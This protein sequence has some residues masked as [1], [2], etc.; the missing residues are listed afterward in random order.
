MAGLVATAATCGPAA[1]Q[2]ECRL[3]GQELLPPEQLDR[4]CARRGV[5]IPTTVSVRSATAQ[6]A[7]DVRRRVN[8]DLRG[9][10]ATVAAAEEGFQVASLGNVFGDVDGTFAVWTNASVTFLENERPSEAFDGETYA[11]LV[12]VDYTLRSGWTFGFSLGYEGSDLTTDFNDGGL[13]SDGITVSPYLGRTLGR[14]AIL[15]LGL[16][17]TRLNYDRR[18]R[19]AG[20]TFDSEFDADRFFAFTNVTGYAPQAWLGRDDVALLG[21]VGFRYTNEDQQSFT[22]NGTTVSGGTIEVGQVTVGGEAQ[23]YPPLDALHELQLFARAEGT[24]DVVQTNRTEVPTVADP[25]DDRTEVNLGVGAV[26]R[27]TERI[28]ADVTYER[29]LA[30]EDIDEQT[31]AVGLRVSF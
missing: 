19:E 1:A 29:I 27:F 25:S 9:D 8:D 30:R 3:P 31:V 2:E 23:Y 11:P 20:T 13:D 4:D 24:V 28:S 26:A 15:D 12:G 5:E 22:E 17:Y 6:T 18:R 10:G 16:G 21:R 14:H 7:R